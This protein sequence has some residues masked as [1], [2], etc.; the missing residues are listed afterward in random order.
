M[1]FVIYVR[2]CVCVCVVWFRVV[3]FGVAWCGV[4]L[5][6]LVLCGL[7]LC[8][9]VLCGLCDAVYARLSMFLH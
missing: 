1:F 7:V 9:L 5:C 2:T 3:W 4:V 8:G 6:G